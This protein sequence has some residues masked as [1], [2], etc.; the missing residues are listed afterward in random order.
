MGRFKA[1]RTPTRRTL[2]FPKSRSIR[3]ALPDVAEYRRAY[4]RVLESAGLQVDVASEG[5]SASEKVKA[6]YDVVVSD[7]TMPGLD[8]IELLR[9]IRQFD[10]DVPVILVTGQPEVETAMKAVELGAFKYLSK[11][12]PSEVLLTTIH[13]TQARCPRSV[14]RPQNR[15]R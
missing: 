4:A 14:G 10:I 5:A 15:C 11:P 1:L 8:G 9:R 3:T 6:G 12:V 13:E 7:I 2:A